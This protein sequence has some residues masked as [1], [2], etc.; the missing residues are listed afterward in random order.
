MFRCYYIYIFKSYTYYYNEFYVLFAAFCS[1]TFLMWNKKFFVLNI[2]YNIDYLIELQD[3]YENKMNLSFC[4]RLMLLQRVAN[5]IQYRLAYLSTLGGFIMSRFTSNVWNN[6]LILDTYDLLIG[7]Y[8]LCN[9]PKVA[10]DIAI[11]QEG[12]GRF[13]GSTSGMTKDFCCVILY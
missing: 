7:A 3:G 13:L 4:Y 11:K 6:F 8:H 2:Y 1:W 12:V 5:D 9:H 10:L